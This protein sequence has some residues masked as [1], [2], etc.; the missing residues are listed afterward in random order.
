M[1]HKGMKTI[2]VVLAEAFRDVYH[3][4]LR[5]SISS[6]M[7]ILD[8]FKKENIKV[9][10]DAPYSDI[11]PHE[12]EPD[13]LVYAKDEKSGKVVIMKFSKLLTNLLSAG[14]DIPE[15]QINKKVIELTDKFK[16]KFR[17]QNLFKFELWPKVSKAYK[18]SNHES[19]SGS[20]GESCMNN[21]PYLDMYDDNKKIKVL[22][23]LDND[24]KIVGRALVWED[25]LLGSS[26]VTYMDRIYTTK[27]EYEVNMKEYAGKEG[28][29]NR[30]M[31]SFQ[32]RT[33]L[34]K[35]GGGKDGKLL[36]YV[37]LDKYKT[38][39]YCDTMTFCF[40]DVEKKLF[41]LSN[42]PVE[43]LN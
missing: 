17:P 24:N 11:K 33:S 36:F 13:K 37:E 14:G 29:Y 32:N 6:S 21:K 7:E 42:V 10:K 38:H 35:N 27:N 25:I 34:E 18:T 43:E 31:Q 40:Y 26:K 23:M 41:G 5:E 15:P 22:V 20:L 4:T 12:K 9:P 39:P 28:W 30:K 16:F 19:K 3:C 8:F 1:E 2:Q